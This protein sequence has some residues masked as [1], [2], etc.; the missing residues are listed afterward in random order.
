MGFKMK[1]GNK[2]SF[3]HMGSSPATREE[4]HIL[5]D[6]KLNEQLAR[7]NAL[8]TAGK[9]ERGFSWKEAGMSV[10]RGKG[11]LGNIASGMGKG[12]YKS[13]I[14]KDKQTKIAGKAAKKLKKQS[15]VSK[16]RKAS[17]LNTDILDD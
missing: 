1:S 2:V 11:L 13:E 9:G 10:L 17:N 16:I 4:R 3:K 7:A 5:R 8:E 14:I 15:M 12:K 6:S